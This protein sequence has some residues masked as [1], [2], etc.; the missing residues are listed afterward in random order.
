[1]NIPCFPARSICRLNHHGHA[2]IAGGPLFR[3]VYLGIRQV[4]LSAALPS[5][6]RPPSTRDLAEQLGISRAAIVLAYE[7]QPVQLS[8]FGA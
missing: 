5:G 6:D 4:I 2:V 3:Q 8:G 7:D 1:M